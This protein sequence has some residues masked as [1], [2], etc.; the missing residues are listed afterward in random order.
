MQARCC[1]SGYVEL[2][3]V[4][5]VHT[6]MGVFFTWRPHPAPEK[7]KFASTEMWGRMQTPIGGFGEGGIIGRFNT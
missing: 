1:S 6:T 2:G 4:Q 3:R 7:Q 5:T